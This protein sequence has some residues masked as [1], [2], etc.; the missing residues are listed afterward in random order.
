MFYNRQN[1]YSPLGYQSSTEY[2]ARAAIT[3]PDVQRIREDQT[4]QFLI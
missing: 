3:Y 1:R 4:E 2:E